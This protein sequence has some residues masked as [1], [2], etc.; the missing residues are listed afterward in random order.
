MP[1]GLMSALPV[2]SWHLIFWGELVRGP[3]I[4]DS[5]SPAWP[6]HQNDGLYYAP[7]QLRRTDRDGWLGGDF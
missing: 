2:L 7:L 5:L 6:S 3:C 1:L 4:G